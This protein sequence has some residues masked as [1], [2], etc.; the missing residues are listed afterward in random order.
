M[1]LTTSLIKILVCRRKK[2]SSVA[3][4]TSQSQQINGHGLERRGRGQNFARGSAPVISDTPP[5]S[6]GDIL[7]RGSTVL[8][9]QLPDICNNH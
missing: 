1:N 9:N 7:K 4:I 6:L 5:I 2:S 3:V 8:A